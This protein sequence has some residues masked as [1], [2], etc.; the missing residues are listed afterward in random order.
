[1]VAIGAVIEVGSS[2]LGTGQS[3]G[4]GGLDGRVASRADQGRRGGC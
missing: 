1:M 3:F 4:R 2:R